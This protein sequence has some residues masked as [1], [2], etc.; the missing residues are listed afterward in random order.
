MP[1][2]SGDAK[3]GLFF[4]TANIPFD[5]LDL[6]AMSNLQRPLNC[7]FV[8]TSMP[9]GGAE[10]LLVNL[11]R[12]MDVNRFRPEVVCLKEPGPLGDEIAN[13][14]PLHANMIGG[15]YDLAV[16]PRLARLF[17]QRQT[18]AVIT[19][20]AG[21]KMFWGRL[22]AKFAGVPVIASA[23]HSTG[24]PDG[25]GRLNR[26]LTPITDAFIGVADSHGEFLRDFEKFPAGKVNVIRNGIDC[27]RFQ[28]VPDAR[29]TVREELGLAE[30]TPLCGIVAALRSEKNHSLL[31]NA[32]AR[33]TDTHPDLN[34]LVVGEGPE[35]ATI[36]P[37]REQLGL[38]S[39]VH[40]LGNRSDTPRLLSAMDVFTLCSLN[41]A[42]PVSILEAL[43]C[44]TPVIAT[45]VGSISETVIEGETGMLV[46]S[47][48]VDGYANA[49]GQ[50]LSDA[51]MRNRMGENGRQRVI[52]TGSLSSMVAGYESLVSGIYQAKRVPA[53]ATSRQP[54]P[55][56]LL[57]ALSRSKS[58]QSS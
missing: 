9:V 10:T 17:R 51:A 47:E 46:A 31:L 4:G 26:L 11:M 48:D 37:L 14:F 50:L 7:C 8:I 42:S 1:L 52:K 20:G 45:D 13:E 5:F 49:L 58:V 36:E 35:R 2:E 30:N 25:V 34:V 28:A 3:Y 22:A 6:F 18:D 56:S 23:L 54:K 53:L 29:K 27:D 12:R 33:L 21:D 57:G 19:V 15:K 16:V 55:A 44:Q 40:L 38:E 43:A 32:V 41:E 24:W 39:R